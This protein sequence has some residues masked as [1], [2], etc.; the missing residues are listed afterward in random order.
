MTTDN[1]KLPI[2]DSVKTA[3]IVVDM[4]NA[5]LSDEGSMAKTGMDVSELKKPHVLP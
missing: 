5:S 2:L 3:M 4:Q 1:E